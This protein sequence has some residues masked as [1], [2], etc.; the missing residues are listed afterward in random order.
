M[1]VA[2]KMNN[3]AGDGT[4]TAIILA[5]EMIKGGLLAVA[6]GA[7]PISLKKGM[8][9]T[10]SELVKVLKEK[11]LPVKGRDDI[12]GDQSCHSSCI[13]SNF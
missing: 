13:K 7:N 9:K 4:T 10:V 12:K 3:L 1:Q 2:S 6:F 11:S 8:E 5:R